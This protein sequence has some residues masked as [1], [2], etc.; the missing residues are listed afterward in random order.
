MNTADLRARGQ[1]LRGPR[2]RKDAE[3]AF[4]ANTATALPS[5]SVDL[6]RFLLALLMGIAYRSDL[7]RCHGQT[8]DDGLCAGIWHA[9]ETTLRQ[10]FFN[11]LIAR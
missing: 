5:P 1:E 7:G 10:K 4:Q 6:G 2:L 8:S 11:N 9:H 3:G